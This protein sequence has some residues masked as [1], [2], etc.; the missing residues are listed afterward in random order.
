MPVSALSVRDF[1]GVPASYRKM[2]SRNMTVGV[3]FQSRS[4]NKADSHMHIE[5]YA[6]KPLFMAEST[7]FPRLT[8]MTVWVIMDSDNTFHRTYF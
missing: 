7:T 2:G 5:K 6:I 8:E 4:R 1:A 3:R